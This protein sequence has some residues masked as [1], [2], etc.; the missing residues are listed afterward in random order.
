[1]LISYYIRNIRKK[2]ELT[3]PQYQSIYVI[4]EQELNY[5]YIISTI[6]GILSEETKKVRREDYNKVQ[7]KMDEFENQLIETIR[8]L[9][10]LDDSIPEGLKTISSGRMKNLSILLSNAHNT[11]KQLKSKVR[12]HKKIAYLPTQV[13]EKKEKK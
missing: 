10:K 3:K 9:R 13:E 4:M 5:E 1:M 12:E 8:E 11:I 7:F 6:R 2:I